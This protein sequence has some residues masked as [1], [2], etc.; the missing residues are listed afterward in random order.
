M[1]LSQETLLHIQ[2]DCEGMTDAGMDFASDAPEGV[3]ATN[4][5]LSVEPSDEQRMDA[6]LADIKG[7][8][9]AALNNGRRSGL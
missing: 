1:E 3:H 5:V 9:E 4:V 6:M 8:I 7:F 2:T